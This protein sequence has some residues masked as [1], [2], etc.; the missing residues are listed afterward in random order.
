MV[1]GKPDINICVTQ[2]FIKFETQ[3]TGGWLLWKSAACALAAST[4]WTA[5]WV[6]SSCTTVSPSPVRELVRLRAPSV[7]VAGGWVRGQVR[8][9]LLHL[10]LLL[11]V[12][13]N[14]IYQFHR[15]SMTEEAAGRGMLK[16][17][18]FWGWKAPETNQMLGW[19][20]PWLDQNDE[21]YKKIQLLT[22]FCFRDSLCNNATKT[23]T[24]FI[25][26]VFYL[27]NIWNQ[28]PL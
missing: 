18:G 6:S 13:P 20:L 26:I 14:K 25:F 4:T 27:V 16:Y 22:L 10:H 5:G 3:L 23:K 28:F 15:A 7:L 1:Y 2:F 11:Q 12:Y 9:W 19:R 8:R 24:P 21:I 17:W